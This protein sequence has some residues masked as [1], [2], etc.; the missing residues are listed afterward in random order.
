MIIRR[1]NSIRRLSSEQLIEKEFLYGATNYAPM[2]VVISRAEGIYVWDP[3]GRKYFD[4]VSAHSAV[5]Q[6]HGHPKI[7]DAA[8]QQIKVPRDFIVRENI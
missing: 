2:K 7:I 6:G 4:F 1:L 5:N 3:E 8:V